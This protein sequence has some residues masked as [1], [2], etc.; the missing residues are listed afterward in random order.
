[1]IIVGF[2]KLFP[3]VTLVKGDPPRGT[4]RTTVS[5]SGRTDGRGKGDGD[6]HGRTDR[7]TGGRR[8]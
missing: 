7:R 2:P 1:M 5:K 8:D 4:R 6:G 3:T